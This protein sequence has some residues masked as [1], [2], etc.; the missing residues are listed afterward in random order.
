MKKD[1]MATDEVQKS[2]TTTRLKPL[3]GEGGETGGPP[4]EGYLI[5]IVDDLVDNLTLLSLDLQQQGYRVVTASDGEQAVRVASLTR[6]DIILMDIAMPGSDGLEAT[7]RLRADV[8]M[9]KIPIVAL[10]AYDTGGFRRAAADAGFDGY[11][12]KPINFDRLHELI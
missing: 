2:L 5:L 3:P 12:T 7:R 8:T 4:P 10:T 11:L 6:P 9:E 1:S